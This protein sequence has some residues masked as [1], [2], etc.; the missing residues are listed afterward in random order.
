MKKF[1]Y[2]KN[3]L[4][5]FCI[6]PFFVLGIAG[7]LPAQEKEP[8][9]T[10]L[11][12]LTQEELDWQNKHMLKVKKVK[13]NKL[14]FERLNQWQEKKGRKTLEKDRIPVSEKGH[15]LEVTTGEGALIDSQ[16]LLPEADIPGSVDNSQLKFF[17]PIRS[18]GSLNSC[19]TF[20][21]VYYAMTHMYAMA[22]DLDAKNGGDTYRL[23]PKWA[24]NMVNGGE[25]AGSWYYWAYEIGQKHGIA[26]WA[27]FPYDSNYRE[28][29][30]NPET[31]EDSLYRRFD[32]Y[33]MVMDTDKDTGI[34]QVK[35]MLLNGYILNIPTYI[36]SWVW[37]TIGNDPATADDDAFAGKKA[38]AWVNGTN[39]YHAMTVVGYNDNIWVDINSNGVVDTGEKGAFRIANSWGTGWGEAGF[40]WMS[41]DALKN[42]SAVTGGPSTGRVY[43]WSPARAHWVTAKPDYEPRVIGKFIL[44]HLKRNQIRM[45][46]GISDTNQSIP[47]S[48]WIP[49]MI[50]NQGGAYAF[51]G[52]TTAVDG[53]FV[54]DL[55]DMIPSGGGIKTY[56]L[57]VEDSTAIDPVVLKSFV[58][59]DAANGYVEVASSEAPASADGNKVYAT[60][61]YNFNDGNLA[62]NASAQASV[63][64]GT[65]PLRIGFDGSYSSD[66]DG[67]I[68]SWQWNFGDGASA[69]GATVEHVYDRAGVF[70]AILT[71]TDNLGATASDSMIIEVVPDPVKVIFISDM[72]AVLYSTRT[73]RYAKV[74]VT[75]VDINSNP[76]QGITVSGAW[77][78]LISGG[79]S[80]ITGS[81]GTV[82]FT[83]KKTSKKGTIT[84]TVNN[85]AISGYTYDKTLNIISSVS[86]P[87]GAR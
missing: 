19:G 8:R 45:T 26:T 67:S 10:G 81:D 27:E 20:S 43:G 79:V 7:N 82:I 42:P 69:Q 1:R 35:Q 63:L 85:A 65:A 86:I 23:S 32:Q 52:T 70:T 38:A 84:F 57:G 48:T 72:K 55:S 41:Y 47:V 29:N 18:Q 21:G 2:F 68:V 5:L 62:P 44:N 37:Q 28:W 59:I 17:P 22:K 39:G 9:M 24:Y 3:L 49:E 14:G 12:E 64:S 54:F 77:S 25:N 4:V 61:D 16:S 6:L 78:G 58:L 15:E 50:Y 11:P 83:S 71:V 31:W 76:I 30:L 73:S 36:N 56:Y 87:A 13:L 53:T 40:A 33:G 66:T 34:S 74:Q 46:L 60:V 75:V 51:N 80:G